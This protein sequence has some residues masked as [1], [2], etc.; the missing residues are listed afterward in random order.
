VMF[1]QP[2]QGTVAV[3]AVGNELNVWVLLQLP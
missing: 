1:L 3:I 2:L